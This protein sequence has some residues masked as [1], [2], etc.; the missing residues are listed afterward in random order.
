[1]AMG[2]SVILLIKTTLQHSLMVG[3]SLV[4]EDKVATS[5]GGTIIETIIHSGVEDM[6]QA[7]RDK[8]V[9]ILG[10]VILTPELMW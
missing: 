9:I 7:I 6:A 4:L 1:M 3:L 2:L 10:L 5:I 8:L